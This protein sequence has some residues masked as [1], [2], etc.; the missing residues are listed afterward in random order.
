MLA[1]V[2]ELCAPFLY[3][4]LTESDDDSEIGIESHSELATANEMDAACDVGVSRS[5][6]GDALCPCD[7]C[8]DLDDDPVL[9][10][11]LYRD[12]DPYLCLAR[13][14][15]LDRVPYPFLDADLWNWSLDLWIDRFE[16]LIRLVQWPFRP[17]LREEMKRG[18][19]IVMGAFVCIQTIRTHQ[20][21]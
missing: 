13:G 12:L 6:N 21:T 4:E 9:D 15:G 7:P 10:P 16:E 14:H 19:N 2:E 3:H 17:D 5:E 1:P 11:Y 20:L 8:L 18:G